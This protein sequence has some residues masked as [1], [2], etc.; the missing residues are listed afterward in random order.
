MASWRGI[1]V[2]LMDIVHSLLQSEIFK[3][4]SPNF[5]KIV[6]FAMVIVNEGLYVY[7]LYTDVIVIKFFL[8]RAQIIL[9]VQSKS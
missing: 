4:K 7:D 8:V 2:G 3:R 1:P 9:S 6:S 5:F